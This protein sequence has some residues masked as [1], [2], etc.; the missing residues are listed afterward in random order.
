MILVPIGFV[1][2]HME[3]QFDLDYQARQTC[4]E[5]GL[6]MIR[7]ATVGTDERFIRMIRELVEERVRENSARKALGALGPSHDVCP[8]EC[9]PS[10]TRSRPI[11]A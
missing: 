8:A 5:L 7:A 10:G 1:S 4:D 6:N 11:D 3:V 9:C 2:D